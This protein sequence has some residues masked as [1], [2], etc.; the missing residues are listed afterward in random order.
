VN[1]LDSI[2]AS[3]LGYY[4]FE[5]RLTEQLYWLRCFLALKWLKRVIRTLK[6]C[7]LFYQQTLEFCEKGNLR[8]V[9]QCDSCLNVMVTLCDCINLAFLNFLREA[10]TMLV[11]LELLPRTVQFENLHGETIQPCT[12]PI[13]HWVKAYIFRI[14][15]LKLVL[16]EETKV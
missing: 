4:G 9:I 8:V 5:S 16:I 2:C 15:F 3:K 7:E 6:C 10:E 12:S 1:V 13:K 14:L 11:G